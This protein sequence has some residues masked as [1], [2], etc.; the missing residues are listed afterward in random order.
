MHFSLIT[1]HSEQQICAEI[2]RRA[3]NLLVKRANSQTHSRTEDFYSEEHEV[4]NSKT[5]VNCDTTNS[6]W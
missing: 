2:N 3:S 4:L 5:V 6:L 1:L